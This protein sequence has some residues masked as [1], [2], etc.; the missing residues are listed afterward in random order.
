MK[1]NH[2]DVIVVGAGSMG[3]AAG[4][5]LAKSGKR[6][7]LLDSFHPPHNNGSHHGDTRIIRY[8]YGEGAEYVPLA[9][10]AQELW[11]DLEKATGKQ[12]FLQTGVLNV[13]LEKTDFIQNIISSSQNY[14]LPLEVLTSDEVNKRWPGISLS[15]EYIGCFEPTSGVLK[16]EE[17]ISAYREL[18]EQHG[19]SIITN[20][21]VKEIK[22]QKDRVTVQSGNQTFYSDSLVVSAGAWSGELLSMLDLHLPLRPIRKTFAWFAAN[23]NLYNHKDFPAFAFTTFK[24]L[25]YG[26]PSI[27]GSGLKVGRHDGGEQINPDQPIRGFGELVED[28]ADLGQFLKSYMPHTEQLKYGKTCMYTLTPDEDFIIDLHPAYS[29]VAIAAG[30]SGHGFKFSSAVGQILSELIN[31]GKTEQDISLFTIERFI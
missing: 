11:N 9:L 30:F 12:L 22:V 23:E 5:F 13:G 18:A 14:S 8:A 25:Y 15:G 20:T 19:A 2:Y 1:S 24:G 10:K 4:Y 16:P 17:C 21:R 3:M 7:L 26:F 27:D 29:N 31:L 6:T 28:E